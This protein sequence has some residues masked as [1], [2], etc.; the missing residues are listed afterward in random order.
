L[1]KIDENTFFRESTLRICGSIEIETAWGEFF[2]YVKEF[3]PADNVYLHYIKLEQKQGIVFGMADRRGGRQLD[4]RFDHPS[5]IWQYIGDGENLPEELILNRADQHPMGRLML[6]VV[7]VETKYSIMMMRLIIEKKEIG[8]VGFG[9]QGWDRFKQEDLDLLRLLRAPF[10][11]ALSN[12]RRYHELLGLK[13]LLADDNQYLQHELLLQKTNEIVG[14]EFGLS[15]VMQMVQQVAP[16]SS[17][18]LLQGETGV[19]KEVIANAIHNA[20]QRK[21]QPFIK[22][23]C[24]AIPEML[25]DSEL[26]GHEKGA[27]TGAFEKRRGRFERAHNGTI[28]LDEV[29]ELPVAAQLR[30]LRVLQEMEFEPVGAS[31]SVRVDVRVIAATNRNLDALIEEGRLRQDLYFRLNVFPIKIPPLR[32]RKCDIPALVH[33]FI[34]KKYRKMGFENFPVLAGDAFNTLNA[35]DWPGNVR[36]LENAVEKAMILCRGEALR[37]DHMGD[38]QPGQ[39]AGDQN[40]PD[41]FSPVLDNV[42]S[43]HI[44]RVLKMAGGKISGPGGAADLMN[45][46]PATLRHKMRKLGIPFGRGVNVSKPVFKM[47]NARAK[48]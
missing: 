1:M 44:K 32:D 5:P 28:F 36:E 29:G 30:F 12:S 42:I 48:I 25:I 8:V 13:N 21:N 16:L 11:I 31:R 43:S 33:H 26:F 22:V 10:A 9:A 35:Y 7:G 23:N 45:I 15:Q 38:H 2:N 39:T 37:F 17:P 41:D 24:G 4:I 40:V 27:F 20:S 18:V 34:L 6:E 46:N 19:G 14:A 47:Q 3:I